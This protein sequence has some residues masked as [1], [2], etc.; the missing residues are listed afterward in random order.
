[1]GLCSCTGLRI[2]LIFI[3]GGCDP[4]PGPARTETP[5]G[6]A[7]LQQLWE[8]SLTGQSVA[9]QARPGGPFFPNKSPQGFSA[10]GTQPP[11]PAARPAQP[12]LLPEGAAT[13]WAW[14]LDF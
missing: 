7:W 11:V 1:M 3:W 4:S 8:Q 5:M 13:P 9:A 6:S 12:F 2:T 14:S 10:F